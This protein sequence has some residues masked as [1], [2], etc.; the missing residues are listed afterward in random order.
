[1]RTRALAFAA[2]L[3]AAGSLPP[4]AMAQGSLPSYEPQQRLR[5]ALDTCTKSEV[6]K[7]AYC[8]KKCQEG[9][10]MDM[11]GQKPR[12]VGLKPDAKYTPPKPGYQPPAPNTPRKPPPPG[13]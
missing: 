9:F 8:V 13:A 2:A 1:M 6:M 3:A 7:D 10:R 11:S 4:A 5:T 12:C